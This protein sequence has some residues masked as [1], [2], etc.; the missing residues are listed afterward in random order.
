MKSFRFSFLGTGNAWPITLSKKHPFYDPGNFS[1]LANAS[2][3]I[4]KRI[5][6]QFYGKI[7][8]D[9]GHGIIPLLIRDDNR[10]PDALIITHP[11]ADHIVSIDWICHSY[12]KIHNNEKFLPLYCSGLCYQKI[13]RTFPNLEKY[14]DFR[15]LIAGKTMEIVEM[16]EISLIAYPVYHG[17]AAPGASMLR[18][19][20]ENEKKLLLTGD[21]L[22]PMLRKKDYQDLQSVPFIITDANNRFPYP[23]SNH[24][25]VVSNGPED[26]A[27]PARLRSFKNDLQLSAMLSQHL[28]NSL[29]PDNYKYFDEWLSGADPEIFHFSISDFC[30]VIKPEKVFPVHYSGGEDEKYYQSHR[31]SRKEFQNWLNEQAPSFF[32]YILPSPGDGFDL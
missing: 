10:L 26:K 24:W 31:L 22:T 12:A 30:K 13:I 20:L 18:F 3:Q 8:V 5:D 17:M 4:E 15:E 19:D 11:H 6:N 7:L 27:E 29:D 1:H 23:R 2:Y 28:D 9:A 21:V 25:S 32:E 14:L 16:A